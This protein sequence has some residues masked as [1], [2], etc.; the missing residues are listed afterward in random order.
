MLLRQPTHC[1]HG[2][3]CSR[4]KQGQVCLSVNVHVCSF[5]NTF[6]LYSTIPDRHT[7][8]ELT[9]SLTGRMFTVCSHTHTVL[10]F[11]KRIIG[12][13]FVLDAAGMTKTHCCKMSLSQAL[14][15]RMVVYLKTH[16]FG[17]QFKKRNPRTHWRYYTIILH[18]SDCICRLSGDVRR[19]AKQEV[20][21]KPLSVRSANQKAGEKWKWHKTGKGAKTTTMA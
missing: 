14:S 7:G 9:H 15:T 17:L 6:P 20:A 1:P 19:I 12:C 2:I 21:I 18:K 3:H 4:H 13:S 16:P 10:T 5:K 11:L 8:S